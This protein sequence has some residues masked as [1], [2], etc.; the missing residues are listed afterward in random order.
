MG[1]PRDLA[2]HSAGWSRCST[3][4]PN[5][6]ETTTPD[7]EPPQ[8]EMREHV[9][10]LL[11]A[12]GARSSTGSPSSGLGDLYPLESPSRAPRRHP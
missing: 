11:E 12:A 7:R 1:P 8:I 6:R 3:I 2:E 9:L 5:P 10:P 4:R